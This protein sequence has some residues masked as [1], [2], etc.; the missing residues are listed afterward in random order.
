MLAACSRGRVIAPFLNFAGYS[1]SCSLSVRRDW[2]CSGT[3][4]W[5]VRKSSSSLRAY[6]EGGYRDERRGYGYN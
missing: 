1:A 5:N 4:F 3:S 6:V 2:M